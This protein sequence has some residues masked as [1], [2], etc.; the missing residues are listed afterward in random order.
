MPISVNLREKGNEKVVTSPLCLIKNVAVHHK[1]KI[2][3]TW[4]HIFVAYKVCF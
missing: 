4:R 2:S 3:K 1:F